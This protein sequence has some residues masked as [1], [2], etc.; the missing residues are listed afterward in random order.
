MLDIVSRFWSSEATNF[1]NFVENTP[2]NSDAVSAIVITALEDIPEVR[3]LHRDLFPCYWPN[4][5]LFV[6]WN[7]DS[8]EF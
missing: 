8:L 1:K 4:L 2:N 6:I 3:T 7:R 5:I